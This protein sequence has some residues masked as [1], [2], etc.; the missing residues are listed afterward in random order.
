MYY[1]NL[2]RSL[3]FLICMYSTTIQASTF[4]VEITS[5][6]SIQSF[7]A[8]E[9]NGIADAAFPFSFI[10]THEEDGTISHLYCADLLQYISNDVYEFTQTDLTELHNKYHKAA[11]LI[12]TFSFYTNTFSSGAL[13]VAIWEVIHE[14]SGVFDLYSGSFKVLPDSFY[15][16][17]TDFTA[18]FSAITTSFLTSYD[19]SADL[20]QYAVFQ[21]PSVQDT[22]GEKLEI[23]E[24]TTVIML[25]IAMIALVINRLKNVSV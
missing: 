13:Q 23:S 12:D 15:L 16:T 7:V 24:P 6:T 3:C 5:D 2:V 14:S 25:I 1:L 18:E 11:W 10:G 8:F 19:P 4:Y 20:S 9:L 21:N 17:F 22:I